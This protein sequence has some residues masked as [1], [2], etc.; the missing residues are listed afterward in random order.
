MKSDDPFHVVNL[1]HIISIVCCILSLFVWFTELIPCALSWMVFEVSY[2]YEVL[3]KYGRALLWADV[4]VTTVVFG[5]LLTI[6]IGL[7]VTVAEV[8]AILFLLLIPYLYVISVC[9]VSIECDCFA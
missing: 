3:T 8:C 1:F 2:N 6:F 5:I 9:F 7:V 4:L